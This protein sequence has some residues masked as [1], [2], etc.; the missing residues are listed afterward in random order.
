MFQIRLKYYLSLEITFQ[1]LVLDF[2]ITCIGV[3]NPY[4]M[5]EPLIPE[6][7]ERMSILEPLIPESRERMRRF[8]F[9]K[10]ACQYQGN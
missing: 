2:N 4:I 3:L 8:S 5:L 6:S 10:F 7:R 1:K 9:C